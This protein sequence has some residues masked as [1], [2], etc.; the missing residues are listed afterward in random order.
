MSA[1]QI[2]HDFIDL[3]IRAESSSQKGRHIIYN[4]VMRVI[5]VEALRP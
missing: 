4:P 2:F 5:R 3:M 1:C